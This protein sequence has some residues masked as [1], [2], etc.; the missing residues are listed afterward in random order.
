MIPLDF[1][2]FVIISPLKRTLSFIWRK[3]NP[4]N[5]RIICIKFDWILL[6]GS[7]ED[8]KKIQFIFTLSLLSPVGEGRSLS[9]KQT[10]NPFPKDD[11]C[12]IWLKLSQW[13]W[14]KSWIC[15]SLHTDRQT[16]DGQQAIRITHLSFQ[17]R[18]A[19]N[20][21]INQAVSFWDQ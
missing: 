1:Y 18:W 15:K 5:P 21:K 19:N 16:D 4:L 17:L 2:I 12:Q 7:G 11:L 3:L 6:D 20:Y 14:K 8:F 10:W 9:I 13:F